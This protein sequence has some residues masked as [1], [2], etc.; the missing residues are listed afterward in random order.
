MILANDTLDTL[1]INSSGTY[2]FDK[3]FPASSIYNLE[4]IQSPKGQVC[5]LI[6]GQGTLELD[7]NNVFIN[8]EDDLYTI[9]GK[10]T[11]LTGTI[12]LSSNIDEELILN[13]NGMFTFNYQYK[14]S[15]EYII[16]ISEAPT[17]L[18]C[19]I[20]NETGVVNNRDIYDVSIDCA[21]PIEGRWN[22]GGSYT[23]VKFLSSGG[24]TNSPFSC[25]SNR[26]YRDGDNI[27]IRSSNCSD[28]SYTPSFS[29]NYQNL[30]FSSS[31]GFSYPTCTKK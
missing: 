6:N 8:C 7:V 3:T 17:G 23:D 22:C 21:D 28:Y 10:V 4:V 15:E 31:D 24:I 2:T 20:E 26:W 27:I 29:N 9:S 1:I 12:K 14:N 11:G 18:L 19:S 5:D 13:K 30:V 16:S 25:L